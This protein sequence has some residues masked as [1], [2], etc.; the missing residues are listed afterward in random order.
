MS[1]VESKK[2]RV[3]SKKSRVDSKMSRVERKTSRVQ[4]KNSRVASLVK[5]GFYSNFFV[6]YWQR[7]KMYLYGSQI[8]SRGYLKVM[9]RIYH[10]RPFLVAS[11]CLSKRTQY[12]VIKICS[13]MPL[14]FLAT[15]SLPDNTNYS[16]YYHQRKHAT[17]NMFRTRTFELPKIRDNRFRNSYIIHYTSKHSR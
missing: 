6:H 9:T 14:T 13:Y 3:E 4:G 2:S 8:R 16:F 5:L 11:T 10:F 1:R 17:L 12:T 15:I 7:L